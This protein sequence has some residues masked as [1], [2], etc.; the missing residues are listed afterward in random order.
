MTHQRTAI[1]NGRT[2]HGRTRE[3]RRVKAK[4][5]RS[6]SG[7]AA[8]DR[9]LLSKRPARSTVER[10]EKRPRRREA[11][12]HTALTHG[13]VAARPD[14]LLRRLDALRRQNGALRRTLQT[15]RQQLET[16]HVIRLLADND[17]LRTANHRLSTEIR[18]LRSAAA[19]DRSQHNAAA[20]ATTAGREALKRLMSPQSSVNQPSSPLSLGRT[21]VRRQTR[22]AAPGRLP[23]LH[24]I[25]GRTERPEGHPVPVKD[26][27][28]APADRPEG[29]TDPQT[30]T[31]PVY[32]TLFPE[33]AATP[34]I[35]PDPSVWDTVYA[36]VPAN[37]SIP[38]ADF[39]A[40]L[41]A[42][43]DEAAAPPS[44]AS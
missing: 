7:S 25:G 4:R 26:Q 19:A 16:A 41:A 11:V 5:E 9:P 21:D 30:A 24:G 37:Y 12:L 38:D 18:S 10:G 31:R 20:R 13:T 32:D 33:S 15:L 1:G 3:H 23:D 8:A 29:Q 22:P 43:L 14:V 34:D 6:L 17:A 36:S 39:A 28:E 27:P 42:S 35:V 40:F 2:A 44:T